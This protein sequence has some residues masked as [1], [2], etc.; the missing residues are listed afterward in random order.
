VEAFPLF[1]ILDGTNTD[2]YDNR[3]EPSVQGGAKM[4]S[5]FFKTIF[6]TEEKKQV[7]DLCIGEKK[8]KKQE[9]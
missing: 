9:A 2:D 5:A 4:G 8:E 3:V 6:A 7:Q 1:K